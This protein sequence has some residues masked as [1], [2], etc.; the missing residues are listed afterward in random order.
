M[1]DRRILERAL[2]LSR[3]GFT[4]REVARMCGVSIG[5]VRHWKYG[6]RRSKQAAP[7]K[8]DCPRCHERSLDEQSYAYLLGLYLGDGHIVHC[9]KDVF[10]LEIAC[11]DAWPGLIHAAAEAIK[12][13]MPSNA[14]G[15]RQRQGCTMVGVLS[16]HLPC[17]FPQHGPGMKH[18]RKIALAVWQEDIVTKFAE[19]FVRGLIHS[20][21]CRSMNRVRRPLKGGDRWYEYPRYTF[22][23]ESADIR[24]LFTDAL[25]RLG[26]AWK[27]MN[28]KTISIAR[29]EA[30]ARLDEFV[31]PKY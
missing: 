14:V 22:V 13:V 31:G 18:T 20:D 12:A 17:L 9:P 25:D 3:R 16:K 5:A 8:F 23:N 29:R 6:T 4:D 21:G 2:T 30:V 10:R 1:Y 15:Y 7:R 26:I 27:Q 11:C 28:R 19:E 24:R